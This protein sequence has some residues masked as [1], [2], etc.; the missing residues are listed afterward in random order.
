[1]KGKRYPFL[2]ANTDRSDKQGM[3][4]WSIDGK[5]DFLLFDSSGI[6]GLKNFMVKDD[7]KIL[8]IVLKGI[9]NLKEEKTEIN[10][11]NVNFSINSYNKLSKDEKNSLSEI[12]ND[13]LHF[14]EY[15]A[16]FFSKQ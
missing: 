16:P 12:A 10:L 1:M 2:I 3:D 4:W 15:F 11:V 6:K 5:R 13:F 7:K 9:E 8:K 14:I